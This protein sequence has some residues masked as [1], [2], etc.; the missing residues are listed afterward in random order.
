MEKK[1]DPTLFVNSVIV[2][3]NG[4]EN[5]NYYDSSREKKPPRIMHRIDD[6]RAMLVYKDEVLVDICDGNTTYS[7][8]VTY[9]SESKLKLITNKGEQTILIKNITDIKIK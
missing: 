5:Q 4:Q 8:K 9:L 3:Q 6:L 1:N 2:Q 7:G